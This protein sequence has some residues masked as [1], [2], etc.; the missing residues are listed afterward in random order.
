M[1][2]EN[3]RRLLR[4]IVG[5]EYVDVTFRGNA[6]IAAALG[7]VV[8]G[9][10][11]LIPE[12]GGWLSYRT[13]PATFGLAVEEVHCLDSKIDLRALELKLKSGGIGALLYQNPGGYF[14]A[15]TISGIYALCRKYGCLVILDVSGAIGT[16]LWDYKS[17]DVLVGS[18]GKGK[19]VNAGCG[20]FISCGSKELWEK[21][22]AG[23]LEL[24]KDDAKLELVLRNLERLPERILLLQQE[25]AKVL[26]DL[27]R[28][29]VV[30][31]SD[32]GFGVVVRFADSFEKEEIIEYCAAH[33][34]EW[35]ECPRYIRLNKPAISI[36]L[37]RMG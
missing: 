12:E 9:K 8:S 22:R 35:T 1:L 11:I 32:Y 13:L 7:L 4:E 14:A 10:K 29:N 34:L 24:L 15:Q 19:L 16:L 27:S 31:A 25:R 3:I 30:H 37:K 28:F 18:F 21:L 6:A 23:K 33:Q 26:H 36:E 17:A 2:Q 5:H 20:G